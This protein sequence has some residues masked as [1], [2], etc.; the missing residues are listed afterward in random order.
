MSTEDQHISDTNPT[1]EAVRRVGKWGSAE[2]DSLTPDAYPPEQRECDRWM[3]RGSRL[4]GREKAPYAPWAD[5]DGTKWGDESNWAAFETAKDWADSD[6]RVDGLV[7]IHRDNGQF[8]FVDGDDVRCPETGDVHPAFVAILEHLGLTYAD[9]SVSGTGAHA[10]YEGALPGDL[11][12]AEWTLDTEPWGAND[13]LPAIEIYANN[14]VNAATG[15]HVSGTPLETNQ[16]NDDA[17]VKILEAVGEYDPEDSTPDRPT[18]EDYDLNV[19]EPSA[20]SSGEITGDIRDLFAALDRL[21]PKAVAEKTIVREWT[22]NRRSFLPMWG[23][24]ND[25]GTANYVNDKI[26]HD[27]G[28]DG[29]YGGPIIMAAIDDGIVHHAGATPDDVTGEDFFAAVDHLRDLGFSLPLYLPEAESEAPGGER[30]EQTPLWALRKAAVEL[31]VCGREDLVEHETD[32]GETY[33]GFD[34]HTYNATLRALD[35]QE[36]DHGREPIET[37]TRS[38]YYD[39]DLEEFADGDPWM[40]PETM[41]RAC[42]CARE[43]G[44]IGRFVDPPTMALIPLRRD[45][46]GQPASRDMRPGTEQLLC[47][48]Y[49]DIT[50]DDLDELLTEE[51]HE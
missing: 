44:E 25:N 21:N 5:E 18:L 46:F 34:Q 32:G 40:N 16:W 7:F 48:L 38:P 11:P 6:P 28:H 1:P 33:L 50:A 9:V 12:E 2:F 51:T 45:V 47:D 36:I 42:L 43:A 29:G 22:R 17:L 15:D 30:Y 20:T 10:V 4:P 37:N 49:H 31:D 3:V 24:Q 14:H 19:Y 23:S 27:T 39:V 35:E 41:L 26:W 8:A 13:D